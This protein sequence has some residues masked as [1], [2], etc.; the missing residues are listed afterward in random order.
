MTIFGD[1]Q[2]ARDFICVK[3]IKRI[4]A[5]VVLHGEPTT[6]SFNVCI[7]KALTL[8]D[9]VQVLETHYPNAPQPEFR[10]LGRATF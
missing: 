9:V 7:G 2:Q 1:G 5:A 8:L 3:D 10:R 6:G 4:N